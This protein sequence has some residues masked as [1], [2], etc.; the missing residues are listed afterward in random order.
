MF[1]RFLL[2]FVV[3]AFGF[4]AC[5]TTGPA[6]ADRPADDDLE[7]SVVIEVP[8]AVPTETPTTTDYVIAAGDTLG[9]IAENLNVSVDS[10]LE[11][12]AMNVEQVLNIGD[13]IRV[14]IPPPAETLDDDQPGGDIDLS[15]NRVLTAYTVAAGDTLGEIADR[16]QTTTADLLEINALDSVDL[17]VGDELKVPVPS[18]SSANTAPEG[19]VT[20]PGTN[21]L[22]ADEYTVR[23]GDTTGAIA[24]L[25]GVSLNELLEA[26]NMTIDSII[27]V[28]QTLTI[29]QD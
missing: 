14:P 10:I 8:T 11:A 6:S 28:G 24:D 18:G 23:S 19:P 20:A 4:A 29:P 25:H 13:V 3:I 17:T 7:P 1:R 12:N 2:L 16:F 22:E 9:G 5:G 15:G 26:N 21:R 27:Q